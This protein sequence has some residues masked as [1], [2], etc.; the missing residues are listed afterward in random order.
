LDEP[1]D[2]RRGAVDAPRLAAVEL[3]DRGE[4][5][6]LVGGDGLVVLD[7]TGHEVVRAS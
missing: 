5:L 3:D 7:H 6:A 2:H 1:P 4:E